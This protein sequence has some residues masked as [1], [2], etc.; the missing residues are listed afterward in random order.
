M[1]TSFQDIRTYI[2]REA[3]DICHVVVCDVLLEAVALDHEK[4]NTI[5]ADLAIHECGISLVEKN[6]GPSISL[7]DV[8]SVI[9]R[10]DLKDKRLQTRWQYLSVHSQYLK[11]SRAKRVKDGPPIIREWYTR[12]LKEIDSD[13]REHV[14]QEVSEAINDPRDQWVRGYA[15][16]FD[17]LKYH[18]CDKILE[19]W[20]WILDSA[21]HPSKPQPDWWPS[22]IP[23]KRI[24]LILKKDKVRFLGIL[25]SSKALDHKTAPELDIEITDET[26][27]EKEIREYQA[28]LTEIFEL[29]HLRMSIGEC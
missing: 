22:D 24:P 1:K 14:S 13:I 28:I 8:S 3:P 11:Q 2:Y 10:K 16:K 27:N 20:I 19:E 4:K 6:L 7:K 25:L 9:P 5:L 23:H 12:R 18:V 15:E 29:F 17:L 26:V 21:W